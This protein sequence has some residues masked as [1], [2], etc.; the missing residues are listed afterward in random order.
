MIY[1]DHEVERIG[2]EGIPP[3]PTRGD[4]REVGH[5]DERERSSLETQA[6]FSNGNPNAMLCQI[7]KDEQIKERSHSETS[8]ASK[9][10]APR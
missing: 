1:T 10:G 6:S 8:V 5:Q 7:E 3:F 2:S 9:E 4:A